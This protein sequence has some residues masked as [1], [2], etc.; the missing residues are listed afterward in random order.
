MAADGRTVE[1]LASSDLH[2]FFWKIF[3][4]LNNTKGRTAQHGTT[5]FF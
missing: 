3:C 5:E 1:D 4:L 2:C